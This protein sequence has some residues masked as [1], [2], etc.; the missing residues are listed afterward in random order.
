MTSLDFRKHRNAHATNELVISQAEVYSNNVV[1]II[2]SRYDCILL[3][4]LFVIILHC[5]EPGAGYITPTIEFHCNNICSVAACDSL[6][7]A[8]FSIIHGINQPAASRYLTS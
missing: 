2:S 3:G 1:L 5:L 4:V 6:L 7:A 8:A